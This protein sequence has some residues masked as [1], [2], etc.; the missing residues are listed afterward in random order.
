M[1]NGLTFDQLFLERVRHDLAVELANVHRMKHHWRRQ[2]RGDA[3]WFAIVGSYIIELSHN[4][5]ARKDR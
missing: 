5:Y 4:I 1:T 3:D 2:G